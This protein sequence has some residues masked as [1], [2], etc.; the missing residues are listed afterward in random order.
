MFAR[1][2]CDKPYDRMSKGQREKWTS[3]W[4]KGQKDS[5]ASL[6][7]GIKVLKPLLIKRP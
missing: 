3:L 7:I 2:A 4:H 6:S 1:V 5:K